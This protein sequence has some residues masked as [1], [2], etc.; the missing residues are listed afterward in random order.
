MKRPKVNNAQQ[1][2]KTLLYFNK[3]NGIISS[4]VSDIIGNVTPNSMTNDYYNLERLYNQDTT[5][6]VRVHIF[7]IQP[8]GA[9]YHASSSKGT[10]DIE[11]E[12][13]LSRENGDTL[14][15]KVY[16]KSIFFC[17]M[18][19]SKNKIPITLMATPLR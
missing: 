13:I 18:M 8:N 1:M 17:K 4:I 19:D 15:R 14:F 3:T 12:H 6:E 11:Q 16:G 9:Y 5:V 7:I 2:N 10:L